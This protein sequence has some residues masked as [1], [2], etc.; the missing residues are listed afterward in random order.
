MDHSPQPPDSMSLKTRL[1]EHVREH[2][3]G[4]LYDLLFALTWVTLVSALFDHVFTSAPRWA[5][6]L[7]ML[8]AIPA[9][10][11]FLLSLA[12]ARKQQ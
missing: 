10:F 9:Y 8:A 3:T 11:G 5:Y 2:R 6:Y 4:M 12:V 1:G 7:C